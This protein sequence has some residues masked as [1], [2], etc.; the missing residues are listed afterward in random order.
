MS[1]GLTPEGFVPKSLEDVLADVVTRQRADLGPDID[2]SPFSVIGQ[3]NGIFA[4]KCVE[5]W[6]T[7]QELYDAL[8]PDMASGV[9]QDAL[10]SL[11]NTLRRGAKKSTVTATVNLSA[12][13]TI[14]AGAAVA[15]VQGNSVARFVNV[16]PMLNAG[17]A[18]ADVEVLF[19]SQEFGPVVANATT[20]NVIET[21]IAGWNSITNPDDAA[22]GSFVETDAA[23]RIRR[24]NELAAPGGGTVSGIRADLSRVP[25]VLA[26][27]VLE[28]VTD[29]T[30][31]DGL[32]PHSIEAIVRGGDA[33]AIG[34]SIAVNKVGGIQTHGTEPPVMVIDDQGTTYPI[35]FSRPDEV[36]VFL[37]IEV[38]TG[39]EYVGAE[40]LALALQAAT[41]DKLNPAYLDVGTSVYSG[42]MVCVAL[43]VPGV[44]NARVG[45]SLTAITDPDAGLSSIPIASRQLAT[46]LPDDIAVTEVAS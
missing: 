12:A 33:Q 2:T 3:L 31:S 4:S 14:A 13:T 45:L 9:Q 1:F 35:Y 23:Y 15:S 6:E 41:T 26:V 29:V 22:L 11:T 5:L 16:E 30:T 19:E 39:P 24:L 36:A 21:F 7:G 28:N 10:Y 37:A 38:V 8:D 44:L 34:E 18:P 25:D 27:A 17:G 42:R 40:A 20:L 43:E 46:I 32:P